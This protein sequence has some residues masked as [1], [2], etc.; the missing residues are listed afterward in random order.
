[1]RPG[2]PSTEMPPPMAPG[3]HRRTLRRRGPSVPPTTGT[4][5]HR[6]LLPGGWCYPD[7]TEGS[8]PPQVPQLKPRLGQAASLPAD[9][10]G[11]LLTTR[12]PLGGGGQGCIR[13][14]G[15]PEAV[16]QAV[17]GG[18]QSG[19]GPYCR[20]QTPLKLALAVR[21]QWLGVGWAP[22]LLLPSR[23]ADAV[24]CSIATFPQFI[25]IGLD[26]P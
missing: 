19:W 5:Q 8:L 21:G 25:A 15:A 23:G 17:E 7:E 3:G 22:W 20:L 16:R 12:H 2:G 26:C 6:A 24:V 18:C 14:Q 10:Q 1:M 13:T 11:I 9:A 4:S